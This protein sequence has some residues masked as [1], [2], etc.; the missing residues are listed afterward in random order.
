MQTALKQAEALKDWSIK[1]RRY[2][3]QHPELG[4][5]EKNTSNYCQKILTELGYHITPYENYGFIA[6]LNIKNTAKKIAFRADMDAL[7]MQEL[8]THD[9]VSQ[10]I[11]IAHM[12]GHDVHMAIALTT[13]KILSDNKN[14]L[15]TSI[16][17]IFQPCEEITPGGALAMI[18]AGCL[19]DVDE[20]YGL[21][22]DP[23]L[24]TG[25]IG[26]RP[27][28]LSANANIFHGKIIGKG[29]HAARPHTGLDPIAAMIK[30]LNDW[31]INLIPKIKPDVLTITILQAGQTINVIPDNATFS[32]MLRSFSTK[33]ESYV[34]QYMNNSCHMLEQ[35]GY[36]CN[37]DFEIS[38]PS[39]EN[40]QAGVD[41]VLTAA[42]KIISKQNIYANI[43]PVTW[44]EDF[45]YYLKHK[46]GAFFLLGSSN[47]E[48]G[49]TASLHSTKFAIDEDCLAIGAAILA[50]IALANS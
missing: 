22:N 30:T 50:E 5:Q 41:N 45:S 37:I 3:H 48:K 46:P 24:P 12:C 26:I 7:A 8:N 36:K 31:Q 33:T 2:L 20:I 39:I 27:G 34:K 17:F 25:C 14:Q 15:K 9:Y 4:G 47:A 18:Q 23:S 35:Q 43:D 16:R 19:E 38:Y 44:A 49:I 42:E 1:H 40:S 32:G 6:D 13:A 10:N 28:T 29:C 21:H 11:G